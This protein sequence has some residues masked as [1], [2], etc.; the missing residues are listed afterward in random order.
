MERQGD[1]IH[2]DEEEASGG[3]KHNHVRWILL[4]SLVLAIVILSII[5]I[6]GAFSTGA[7][8]GG[9]GDTVEAVTTG[10]LGEQDTT[11][12]IMSTQVE[13]E[14]DPAPTGVDTDEPA[15]DTAVPEPMETTQ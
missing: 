11:E 10:E 7:D 5:W 2:I 12:E 3:Q 8:N 9:R 4:I 14:A 6:T 1:E 13:P 15:T